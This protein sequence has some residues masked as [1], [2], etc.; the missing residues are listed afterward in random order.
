MTDMSF[1]EAYAKLEEIVQ[2]LEG[3]NLPLDDA[4]KLYEKLKPQLTD[5][6]KDFKK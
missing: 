6:L 3:E 1:E 5:K 2:Q 4:L